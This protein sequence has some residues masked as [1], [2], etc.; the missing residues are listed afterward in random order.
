MIIAWDKDLDVAVSP[1][2]AAVHGEWALFPSGFKKQ[3][4]EAQTPVATPV[5]PLTNLS[6]SANAVL[7]GSIYWV[8]K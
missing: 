3:Y 8:C 6:M 4:N 5:I 1:Q 2:R 7:N